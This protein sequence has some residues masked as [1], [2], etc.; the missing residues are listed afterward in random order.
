MVLKREGILKALFDDGTENNPYR[1]VADRTR[2]LKKELLSDQPAS[3]ILGA[4]VSRSIGLPGWGALLA[5]MSAIMANMDFPRDKRYRMAKGSGLDTYRTYSGLP[6]V[7]DGTELLEVAEYIPRVLQEDTRRNFPL[8]PSPGNP[9]DA[10]IKEIVRKA[11]LP[12]KTSPDPD[13]YKNRFDFKDRLE[14]TTLG[15]TAVLAAKYFTAEKDGRPI[16]RSIITYNYDNALEHCLSGLGAEYQVIFRDGSTERTADSNK[17]HIY[18]PHGYLELEGM[19]GTGGESESVIL[20]ESSYYEMERCDYSWENFLLARALVGGTS[21]FIGF[22][23]NDYN[24]RRI[25]KNIGIKD[26][27]EAEDAIDSKFKRHR[28]IVAMDTMI[29]K[30]M[31]VDSKDDPD[32]IREEEGL[33]KSL[34]EMK[35][36]DEAVFER[37]RY[38]LCSYLAL[39]EE[40]WKQK[41]F[42][43]IWTTKADL[44][45]LLD[46]IGAGHC[47]N[48][49][50]AA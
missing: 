47:A 21:V 6:N 36:T 29:E 39:K 38:R 11:L 13:F 45:G 31:F 30:T 19:A 34:E 32:I 46:C 37:N 17:I 41:G 33:L 22:S 8:L 49:A 5:K 25:L 27:R 35:K 1:L 44:P 4:G 50:S 42:L 3:L 15:R 18:H 10:Y 26:Q 12:E 48:H 43:P 16:K 14:A 40:Y 23:G 9:M 7:F 24:F 20:T 2:S 28:L